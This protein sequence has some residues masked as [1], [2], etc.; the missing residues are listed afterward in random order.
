MG[1]GNPVC[2]ASPH[3]TDRSR[4]D[5]AQL[6]RLVGLTML[7]AAS[8]V[9][10]YYTIWTLLMVCPYPAYPL[11][12]SK[13]HPDRI[14]VFNIARSP[15]SMTPTS[16]NRSSRL[17]CGPSAYQSSSSYSAVPSWEAS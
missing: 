15:S 12:H 5:N 17:A 16:S 10:S 1:A 7:V 8:V 2:H 6:D 13:P 9:F 3:V 4:A 11:I 14:H